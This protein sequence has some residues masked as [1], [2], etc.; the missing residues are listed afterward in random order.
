VWNGHEVTA[1]FL[2]LEDV[3]HLADTGIAFI[4]NSPPS[5]ALARI[6]HTGDEDRAW[7]LLKLLV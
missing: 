2:D 3:E 5:N 1:G 6:F 4:R 7:F